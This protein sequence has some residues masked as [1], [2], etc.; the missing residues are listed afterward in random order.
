MYEANRLRTGLSRVRRSFCHDVCGERIVFCTRGV[1]LRLYGFSLST[2]CFLTVDQLSRDG[3]RGRQT[4]VLPA[5][6]SSFSSWNV[7]RPPSSGSLLIAA[8]F[9]LPISASPWFLCGRPRPALVWRV[10][11]PRRSVP[12]VARHCFASHPPG[13]S[14]KKVQLTPGGWPLSR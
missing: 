2:R 11:C 7:R 13:A 12:R 9:V 14:R 1:L 6:P 10:H 5:N 4:S 8:S 3:I